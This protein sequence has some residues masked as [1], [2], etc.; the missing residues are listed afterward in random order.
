MSPGAVWSEGAHKCKIKNRLRAPL[1]ARPSRA[2][3]R[4]ILD[5]HIQLTLPDRVHQAATRVGQ[6]VSLAALD[7]RHARMQLQQLTPEMGALCPSL[8]DGA[9]GRGQLQP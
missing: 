5:L 8:R 3:L 4:D 9:V 7:R 2:L 6:I 1:E